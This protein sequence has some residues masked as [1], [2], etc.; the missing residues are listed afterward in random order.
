MK[1][2]DI[3]TTA[4]VLERLRDT[5]FKWNYRGLSLNP[6]VTWEVI[7]ANL[8]KPWEWSILS[9]HLGITWE[10]VN[11]HSDKP[12]SWNDI[13]RNPSITWEIVKANPDKPWKWYYLSM[14]K[15]ITWDIIQANPDKQW[16][17]CK[18]S[19]TPGMLITKKDEA[20]ISKAR[21]LITRFQRAWRACITDPSHPFCQRRLNRE[22]DALNALH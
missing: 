9:C 4:H 5:K 6:D 17:W 14:N 22:W 15:S 3:I 19:Y 13:S 18:L 1:T 7:Q 8:E 2:H 12:W 10:A 11:A 21:L 20:R 16:H